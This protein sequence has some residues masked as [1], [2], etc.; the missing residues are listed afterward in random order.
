MKKLLTLGLAAGM[1]MAASAPASAVDVKMDGSFIFWYDWAKSY[2][3]AKGA[4][5][6]QYEQVHVGATFTAS[7]AL[8]G[9]FALRGKWSLGN[10]GDH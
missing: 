8:S 1:I 4:S 2:N 6:A 9:Y 5:N 7:E 3:K 10:A